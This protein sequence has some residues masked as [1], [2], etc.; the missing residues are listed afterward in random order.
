M[1][2][3]VEEY[4]E[5]L[6]ALL[7][8]KMAQAE[9][10]GLVAECR[11]HL[12]E[13]IEAEGAAGSPA[14]I[15]AVL[16]EFGP[17]E[18]LAHLLHV[19]T[20]PYWKDALLPAAIMMVGVLGWLLL[21]LAGAFHFANISRFVMLGS[22]VAFAVACGNRRRL[23][24]GAIVAPFLIFATAQTCYF[25]S[26]YLPS[27]EADRTNTM[28][29]RDSVSKQAAL[30]IREEAV[31]KDAVAKIQLGI[32][33]FAANDEAGAASL[34]APDGGYYIPEEVRW[35]ADNQIMPPPRPGSPVTI[36]VVGDMP[37]RTRRMI[38]NQVRSGHPIFMVGKHPDFA[39]AAWNWKMM[40]QDALYR[41]KQYE[42]QGRFLQ[43][44]IPKAASM[45][46]IQR[47]PFYLRMGFLQAGVISGPFAVV[48]LLV[49]VFGLA[50]RAIR[51]WKTG[52][53]VPV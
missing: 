25:A 22:L 9:V 29:P 34:K 28:V 23:M 36:N 42:D 21:P 12:E 51:E 26:S 27:Y 16:K 46:L 45:P 7:N 11:S 13:K 49:W 18:R 3:S 53:M 10:E 35:M 47:L 44:W 19:P 30:A 14:K 4:L 24:L 32:K 1:V 33:A 2:K 39:A 6:R 20:Q 37:E 38:E 41:S 5:R 40:G 43:T 48:S 8:S 17:P 31:Y 52:R 15:R 50:R